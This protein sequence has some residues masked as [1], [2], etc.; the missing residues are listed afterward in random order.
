M[1]ESR[2]EFGKTLL[3]VLFCCRFFLNFYDSVTHN[4]VSLVTR[5]YLVSPST[6]NWDVLIES[7]YV[8]FMMPKWVHMGTLLTEDLVSVP[9]KNISVFGVSKNSFSRTVNYVREPNSKSLIVLYYRLR[10]QAYN[11]TLFHQN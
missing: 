11:L 4:P 8:N 1:K 7:R 6:S 2:R 5:V 10:V 9:V 3:F